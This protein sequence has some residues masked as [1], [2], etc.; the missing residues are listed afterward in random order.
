MTNLQ[1]RQR[2]TKYNTYGDDYEDT[3]RV[4]ENILDS[5]RTKNLTQRCYRFSREKRTL[6]GEF[7][8]A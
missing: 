6:E 5:L 1:T 8:M 7:L 3:Y 2:S 4:F